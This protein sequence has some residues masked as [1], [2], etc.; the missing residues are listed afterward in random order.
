MFTTINP[1][2]HT[3]VGLLFLLQFYL[4]MNVA[5]G[6]TNGFFPDSWTN[7]GS[8]KPWDNLSPT[9]FRDFWEARDDW[10]PTWN[11]E[12]AAMKVDWVRVY[13]Q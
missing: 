13:E 12:D 4:I 1:T 2:C 6:G 5:V 11:G 9:A 3:L 8:P 10:L 7:A